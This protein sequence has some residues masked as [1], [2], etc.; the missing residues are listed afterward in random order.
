MVKEKVVHLMEVRPEYL[1]GADVSCLLNVSGR[2]C[3]GK[4]R[5]SK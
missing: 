3:N 1:I 5:K 2:L 4:G